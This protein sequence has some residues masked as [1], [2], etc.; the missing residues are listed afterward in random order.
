VWVELSG[1]VVTYDLA[2]GETLRVHPGHVGMFHRSVAFDIVTVPGIRN[3]LF[4][5]DGLFLVQL[6]GPGKVWLQSMPLPNL[7]HALEPYLPQAPGN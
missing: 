7:A 6:R 1:E 2:D 3:R 4:G 5:G